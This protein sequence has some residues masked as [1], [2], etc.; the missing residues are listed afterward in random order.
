MSTIKAEDLEKVRSALPERLTAAIKNSGLSYR[1]LEKMTG[2]PRSTI[3]NYATG[4][5][6]KVDFV[7]IKKLASA[8][9]V[10]PE[11]LYGLDE[12]E[13]HKG[14]ESSPEWR[15]I[16]ERLEAMPEDQVEQFLKIFRQQ[17]DLLSGQKGK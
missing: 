11:Y 14:L 5:R 13:P 15:A 17:L 3:G 10:T 6:T 1:D 4:A 12:L 16:M 9:D 7:S 8:L 2:V